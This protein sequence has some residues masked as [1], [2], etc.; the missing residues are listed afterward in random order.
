[1]DPAGYHESRTPFVPTDEISMEP[2]S[3]FRKSFCSARSLK[4]CSRAE[5]FY[6]VLWIRIGFSADQ[7]PAFHHNADRDPD[8]G[9]DPGQTFKS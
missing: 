2:Y 4:L 5:C 3:L 1:M 9:P 8:P 6:P 7:D